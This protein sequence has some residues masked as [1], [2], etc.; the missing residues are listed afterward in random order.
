MFWDF[1]GDPVVKNS[2]SNIGNVGLTS[3]HGTKV[4][5]AVGH[6]K[7]KR[8]SK[9]SCLHLLGEGWS[10]AGVISFRALFPLVETAVVWY[11]GIV[12]KNYC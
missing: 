2:P 1:S 11:Q 12:K 5:H 10:S 8:T 9:S 3:G 7:K 4:P 6:S